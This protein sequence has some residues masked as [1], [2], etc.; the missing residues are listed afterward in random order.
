MPAG[1]PL[2]NQ[3]QQAAAPFPPYRPLWQSQP[4]AYQQQQQQQQPQQHGMPAPSAGAWQ[5]QAHQQ[6]Q[7]QWQQDSPGSY[8]HY[9]NSNA[10]N[11]YGSGIQTSSQGGQYGNNGGSSNGFGNS[12]SSNGWGSGVPG[13]RRGSN[14]RSGSPGYNSAGGS[15]SWVGIQQGGW[16]RGRN[17]YNNSYNTSRG[18]SARPLAGNSGGPVCWVKQGCWLLPRAGSTDAAAAAAAGGGA[19]PGTA[20]SDT[21]DSSSVGGCRRVVYIMRG[22]P[23]AGKSTCAAQLA[24]AAL[25]A[26][27]A[28]TTSAAVVAIHSTDSYFIDAAGVYRFNAQL[29][30]TNHQRNY[31]AFCASLAA[32]VST[33][34]LDNTN[35]QVGSSP[36]WVNQFYCLRHANKAAPHI[37][38]VC[39]FDD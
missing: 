24:A 16:G 6:H 28:A 27:A 32:G 22:L 5:Q 4:P 34:I 31:D 39:M 29:L 7:Q 1:Q 17:G 35:L 26:A 13:R 33:V 10:G 14:Y 9:S 36:C 20:G 3:Q 11:G 30:G 19:A 15:S 18:R 37:Y 8:N 2:V 25:Q 38:V 21:L 12:N 23:G